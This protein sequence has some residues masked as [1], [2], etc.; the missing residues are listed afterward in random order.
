MS[1]F[2][3]LA[4]ILCILVGFVLAIA[5]ER[6]ADNL[7]SAK[8]LMPN[9]VRKHFRTKDP[10]M[11]LVAERRFPF[12]M[13]GEV[14]SA[15]RSLFDQKAQLHQCLGIKKD[16]PFAEA[17]FA[18]LIDYQS[19]LFAVAPQLEEINVGQPEPMRVM[20]NGVWLGETAGTRF[21]I[22]ST[23][24]QSPC[25]GGFVRVQVATVNNPAGSDWA[26]EVFN[27]CER[28]LANGQAYRGKILSFESPDSYSGQTSG[29]TVHKIPLVRREQVV[30]PERI[31]E[32]LERNVVQF[33]QRRSHL[34]RL[35]QTTKKG[36]LLYG[37][38][39]TG[40]THTIH[41]LAK[42]VPDQTVFLI[43]AEQVKYLSDYMTLARLLQ[44]SLVIIEDVDLIARDRSDHSDPA[45]EVLLNKLLNEVDGLKEDA[46]I[47]FI[48]TTNRPEALEA[49]LAARPGRIDQAIEFPLPDDAGREQLVRL[50]SKG[51]EVDSEAAH[52]LIT[53][54]EGVSA[55]F[56][57]EAVRRSIQYCLERDGKERLEVAD[58]QSALEEMLMQGGLL[59]QPLQPE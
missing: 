35:G 53:H 19:R 14:D 30:L 33:A 46:W 58:V 17:S 13:R 31:L 43:S 15:L 20:R 16:Y 47:L 55:A 22:V 48:L 49:A 9:I 52:H 45:S 27:A 59:W 1:G 57:K 32:L 10:E 54:T 29:I 28:A 7:R 12:H 37:P 42:A 51:I 8:R 5:I 36:L 6:I 2:A 11:L 44:P 23:Q 50:Y 41:Y 3:W 39:G 25:S 21:A 26:R 40:K 18:E 4:Y 24:D 38:P 56:I 34:A